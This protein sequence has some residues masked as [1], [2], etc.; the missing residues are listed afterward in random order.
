MFY[1]IEIQKT[2]DTHCAYLIHEKPTLNEAWSQYHL[3]LSAGAISKVP[4]HTAVL[5]NDTG[6]TL[7]NQT[8]EHTDE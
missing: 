4:Y 6:W 3:V 8:Y 7:A 5:I 1:I 2:D